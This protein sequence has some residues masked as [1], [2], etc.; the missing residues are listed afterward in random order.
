MRTVLHPLV[1]VIALSGAGTPAVTG[2]QTPRPAV[3]PK[4][5]VRWLVAR[6]GMQSVTA[7]V[8]LTQRAAMPMEIGI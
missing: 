8:R 3:P 4:Q 5:S 6:D 1:L 2:A 7:A